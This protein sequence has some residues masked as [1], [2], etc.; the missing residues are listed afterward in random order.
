MQQKVS[1]FLM[2]VSGARE[3]AEFYTSV[4]KDGRIIESDGPGV[5][6]EVGGQRFDAYDGGS[7]F[8]FTEGVSMHVRCEDQAEVDY[9]WERLQEDGGEESMCG[10]LKDRYGLS[11][12]IVPTA[13][14]RLRS[15]PDPARAQRAVEAML[16]MRKL[17]IAALEAAAD[18]RE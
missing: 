13:L 7:Y 9:F 2:F 10:W 12:Q 8:S 6:F 14:Y 18:G 3:A 15:D 11:W 4:F 17:D 1:P 5:S 16:K